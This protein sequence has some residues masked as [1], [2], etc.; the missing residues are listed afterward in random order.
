MTDHTTNEPNLDWATA[1]DAYHIING[2]LAHVGAANDLIAL[3]A[4]LLGEAGTKALVE[5]PQWADYMGTRRLMEQLKP[6][7]DKFSATMQEL[8]KDRP[9]REEEE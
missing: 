5:T 7:L 9:D 4:S 1:E 2:L 8:A 3:F 6:E